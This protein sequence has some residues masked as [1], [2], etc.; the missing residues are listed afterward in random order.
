MR[1]DIARGEGTLRSLGACVQNSNSNNNINIALCL[2][3]YACVMLYTSGPLY[4]YIY[5]KHK[6]IYRERKGR[7]LSCAK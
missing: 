2:Y 5:V 4:M 6:N 3:Q 1:N 7:P